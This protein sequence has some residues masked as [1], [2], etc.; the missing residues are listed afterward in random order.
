MNCL[1]KIRLFYRALTFQTALFRIA[2]THASLGY[3]NPLTA[4]SF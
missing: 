1:Y 3:M 4:S 2:D